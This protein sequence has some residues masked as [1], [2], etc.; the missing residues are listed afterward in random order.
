[1]KAENANSQDLFPLGMLVAFSDGDMGIV[2]K[3]V[4]DAVCGNGAPIRDVKL[5]HNKKIITCCACSMIPLGSNPEVLS[6]IS[7]VGEA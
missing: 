2:N 3:I 5:F 7:G 4:R 6:R 1:M